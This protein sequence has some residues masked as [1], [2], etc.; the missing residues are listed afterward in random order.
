MAVKG[1]GGGGGRG[2]EGGERGRISHSQIKRKRV[3][4]KGGRL[5]K[6][7]DRQEENTSKKVRKDTENRSREEG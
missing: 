3:K 5:G 1:G 2:G 4:K 6:E 7:R